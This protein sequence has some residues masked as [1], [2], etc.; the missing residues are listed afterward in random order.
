[1]LKWGKDLG[2]FNMVIREELLKQFCLSKDV[3]DLAVGG[4]ALWIP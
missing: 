2:V 1:M 4:G 3:K